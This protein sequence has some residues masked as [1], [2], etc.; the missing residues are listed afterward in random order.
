MKT[1]ITAMIMALI[2]ITGM[3]AAPAGLAESRYTASTPL[4]NASSGNIKNIQRAAASINGCRV[5]AGA[6]FSFNEI[7]GPRTKAQG[8]V[9]A[10]NARGVSVTGGGVGQVATTLYLAL[11]R[12]GGKVEFTDLSTYGSR[13]QDTYVSDG[14]MAVITDYSGGTDFAFVNRSGGAMKLEMWASET[15]LNCVVT[16]DDAGTGNAQWFSVPT[17]APTAAPTAQTARVISRAGIPCEG[18]AGTKE[19]V[20]LAAKAINSTRLTNG[21]VF[22]FND[23]VGKRTKKKGYEPGT[24]GRGAKVTGG[25]VAQVASV[26]WLAVKQMDNIAIVEKSTYGK[27]YNQKYVDSSADAIVTDYKSNKD[28]SFRYTGA[29]TIVIYTYIDNGVLK[30]DITQE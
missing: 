29:G 27:R 28:F 9:S 17:A 5:E 24:N 7:V 1:R 15:A 10:E 25:G 14:N 6:A 16:V 21:Q 12:L 23:I 19:N 26:V 13:F 2:L 3:V 4:Q 11:Q 18:N 20:R 22:S 30:C 8:Y